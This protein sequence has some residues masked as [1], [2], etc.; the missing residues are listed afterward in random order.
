MALAV[1]LTGGIVLLVKGAS[2]LVEA[3]TMRPDLLWPW[4][5]AAAGVML[6]LVKARFVF[7]KSVRKTLRRIDTLDQPKLWQ[8]FHPGFLVALA[9]MILTGATL[10]RLAHGHYGL[11]IAVAILDLAISTA[12]LCSSRV[13]WRQRTLCIKPYHCCSK[14]SSDS[15]LRTGSGKE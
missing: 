14:N 12:L 4:L 3:A 9:L 7:N 8:V 10:S 11:S 15:V 5:A 1:W 2:L 13:F 6:G